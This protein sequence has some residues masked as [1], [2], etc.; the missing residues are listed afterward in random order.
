MRSVP[1]CILPLDRIV[2]ELFACERVRRL[3]LS[4]PLNPQTS[5]QQQ[6]ACRC[7]IVGQKGE[8]LVAAIWTIKILL[9][10]LTTLIVSSCPHR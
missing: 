5:M 2:Q 9:S 6:V 10:M 3:S 1:S 4:G 8:L 7:D